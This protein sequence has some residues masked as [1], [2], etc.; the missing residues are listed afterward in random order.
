MDFSGS[1]VFPVASLLQRPIKYYGPRA[2]TV[3][4]TTTAI[5]AFI[6][7]QY[8]RR[9]AFLRMRN[10]NIYL[11]HFHTMVTPVAD[12]LI[13]NYWIIWC[14]YIWNGDNFFLRHIYLQ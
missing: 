1:F 9:F 7:M 3:I 5:P 12:I 11:A 4:D 10:I 6:R 13:E 2:R 8:D 14:G